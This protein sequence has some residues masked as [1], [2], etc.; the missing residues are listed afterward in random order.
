MDFKKLTVMESVELIKTG[1]MGVGDIKYYL[2]E[3]PERLDELYAELIVLAS[4]NNSLDRFEKGRVCSVLG[5]VEDLVYE[6]EGI[7]KPHF[8][9]KEWDKI[10]KYCLDHLPPEE[11]KLYEERRTSQTPKKQNMEEIED[12]CMTREEF[13][14]GIVDG[15]VRDNDIIRY[16][17]DNIV[18]GND[19]LDRDFLKN[20]ITDLWVENDN[21]KNDICKTRNLLNAENTIVDFFGDVFGEDVVNGQICVLRYGRC[22]TKEQAYYYR[23][24]H[25]PDQQTEPQ[26]ESKKHVT[27]SKTKKGKKKSKPRVEFKK[28]LFCEDDND[29]ERYIELFR[30]LI[31]AGES[32]TELAIIIHAGIK[33]AV[34]RKKPSYN[35]LDEEFHVSCDYQGYD[36]AYRVRKHF[37]KEELQEELH[38]FV[39]KIE[40]VKKEIGESHS[41]E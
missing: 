25:Y 22:M 5:Y 3:T 37:P 39:L 34:L 41:H 33:T 21:V 32:G 23:H 18:C 7:H 19:E 10:E 13:I 38:P 29:R 11:R 1:K 30:K 6:K 15:N 28:C 31:G 12:L 24:G 36:T 27:E 40:E 20:L 17:K 2:E 4:N 35:A 8:G 14:K 26:Q 9:E 16:C